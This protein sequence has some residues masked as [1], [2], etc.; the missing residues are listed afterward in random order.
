MGPLVV[1]EELVNL[2]KFWFQETIQD[3]MLF[4]D[5]LF[6]HLQSF[7]FVQRHRAYEIGY[8]LAEKGFKV[9]ITC[10]GD[11]GIT[12]ANRDHSSQSQIRYR[13]WVSLRE[14]WHHLQPEQILHLDPVSLAS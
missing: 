7:N 1:K 2:F 11:T 3:G 10:S 13:V 12:T 4:R 5:E 14:P 6:R 8:Q 9:V